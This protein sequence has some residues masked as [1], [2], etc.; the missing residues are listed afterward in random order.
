MSLDYVKLMASSI[1]QQKTQND[2]IKLQTKSVKHRSRDTDM[3][4][5]QKIEKIHLV[6]LTELPTFGRP[7][8]FS[9]NSTLHFLFEFAS[10]RV[11]CEAQ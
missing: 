6:T 1:Q 11:E 10:T 7:C 9:R 8:R 3:C 5:M 2:I 4:V